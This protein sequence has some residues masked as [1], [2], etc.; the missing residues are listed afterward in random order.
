MSDRAQT[1]TLEA[2]VAAILLLAA[3]GF[4]LHVVAVSANTASPGDAE[5]R[6][7][8]V[9]IASGVLDEAAANGELEEMIMYWDPE[10]ETFHGPDDPDDGFYIGELRE[11]DADSDADPPA[12]AEDFNALFDD[13]AI[14]F[15]IDLY[16]LDEA[17]E[18]WERQRLVESGTPGQDGVTIKQHVT[19]Y[20]HTE[21]NPGM[22]ED[23]EGEEEE[24]GEENGNG[25]NGDPDPLTIRDVDEDEDLAFYAP[26]VEADYLDDDPAVYNVVRVEVVIW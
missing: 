18:N 23:E 10:N 21:L 5:L 2:V 14:R 8:H 3:I 12:F 4:A 20:N 22:I 7:Q 1:F 17:G 6:N 25:D 13:R 9:G 26:R 15:N 24:E 11:E 16:Y 19:L